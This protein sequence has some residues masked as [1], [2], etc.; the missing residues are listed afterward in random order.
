[1][2]TRES[3]AAPNL[4]YDYLTCKTGRMGPL[5]IVWQRNAETA[6]GELERYSAPK[7]LVV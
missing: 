1:M 4:E 2:H 7:D 5:W 6:D 3:L